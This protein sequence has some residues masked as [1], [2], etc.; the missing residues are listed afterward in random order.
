MSLDLC[1]IVADLACE[2]QITQN[3][4]VVVKQP[5]DCPKKKKKYVS[6]QEI[7]KGIEDKN[8]GNE[9]EEIIQVSQSI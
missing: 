4:N 3:N 2:E 1:R 5:K 7:T 6:S 9:N 8:R